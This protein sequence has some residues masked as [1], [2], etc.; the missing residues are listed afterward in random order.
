M[1]YYLI[2]RI[3]EIEKN[4]GA[5]GIKNCSMTEDFFTEHFPQQPIMPGLL[6]MEGL[7][8]LSSWLI[9]FSTDFKKKGLL[10][11]IS[12]A[13]YWNLATPGDQLTLTTEIK[14]SKNDTDREMDFKGT[15]KRDEKKILTAQFTLK[16]VDLEEYESEADARKHYSILINEVT[17]ES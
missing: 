11:N 17:G 8:Q 5:K 14:N 16:V 9:S 6:M 3:I 13:K 15:V 4:A 10:Q 12:V 1:R 2:D 7:V